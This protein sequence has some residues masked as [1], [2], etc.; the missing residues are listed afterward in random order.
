MNEAAYQLAAARGHVM[1]DPFPTPPAEAAAEIAPWPSVDRYPTVLGANLTLQTL[2]NAQR[3]ATTGYRRE[4]VDILDELLER[5]AHTQSVMTQR[6]ISVTGARLEIGPA[7]CDESDEK[8]AIEIA[9][10]VERG[11]RNIRDFNR[12]LVGLQWGVYYGVS[13]C[14]IAWDRNADG[15][16]PTRLHFIHHRRFAFPELYSW[17]VRIWDQGQVRSGTA[18]QD[19]TSRMF[20]IAP[21]DY[22]NKFIV[23]TPM[24]RGDYPTREGLGRVLSWYMAIKLMALRG[25]AGAAERFGKPWVF[26]YYTTGSDGKPRTASTKDIAAA[27]AATKALGIGSLATATLPDSV[28]VDVERIMAGKGGG[29]N[30]FLEVI[31]TCNAE[32]SKAVLT[33]TMTTEASAGGGNRSLGETHH[34]GAMRLAAADAGDL[35]E[36]LRWQLAA[37]IVRL[38]RPDK[39]HLVPIVRLMVEDEPD[40][41]EMIER[42]TKLAL[43]GAPVDADKLADQAGVALIDLPDGVKQRRLAPMTPITPDVLDKM[44]AGEDVTPPA[45]VI[46]APHAPVAGGEVPAANDTKT[47]PRKAAKPPPAQAAE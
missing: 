36:C 33:E 19:P 26:A 38:N 14:E 18:F 42:G 43:S 41:L 39:M 35:A 31:E 2:S 10:L 24:V 1:A 11:F 27:D 4:W 21:S 7:E 30:P 46:A 3:L 44:N 37:A 23:H 29:K 12:S 15:W 8:E 6:I 32:V 28:K 5:D 25:M 22:P 13:G 9:E 45:P 16:V 17:E 34:K 40:A 20:G 47:K